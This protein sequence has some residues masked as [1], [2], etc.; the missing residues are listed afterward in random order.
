M[1]VPVTFN[2][3]S[4]L[5]EIAQIT[6]RKKG[7]LGE[8]MA[9]GS[10]RMSEEIGQESF[11]YLYE[12]KGMEI[13]GHSARGLRQMGIG[14]ATAT[15]GGSH[16][17][18]RP[19]YYPDDPQNDPGFQHMPEYTYNSQNN[20][21]IRDSLVICAFI[22]E[23]AFG[24]QLNQETPTVMQY[25]TGWDMTLDEMVAVAE[26]IYT[27][28]RIINVR[29]GVDRSADTLPYRVMN[30]PIPEGPSKG[31]HCSAEEL[32]KML[33]EYYSLR[34]WNSNGIPEKERLQELGIE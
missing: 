25:I 27:M 12:V 33:D 18:T 13:A 19:N 20:T 23:R 21:A 34:K 29:R 22:Y 3:F 26:R 24:T 6:G 10:R 1:E 30:E 15:R 4:N 16:H 2:Q 8:L 5:A 17:D 9:M 31:W 14:Y 11:K 7:R 28:E 32:S